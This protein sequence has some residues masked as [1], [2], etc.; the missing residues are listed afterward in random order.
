VYAEVVVDT[1]GLK[2]MH[3]QPKKRGGLEKRQLLINLRQARSRVEIP[4][5]SQEACLASQASY[6]NPSDGFSYRPFSSSYR[7]T[8]KAASVFEI[9][10]HFWW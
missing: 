6:H 8:E 10:E 3:R 5:T 7:T 2:D 4:R 1:N 9:L